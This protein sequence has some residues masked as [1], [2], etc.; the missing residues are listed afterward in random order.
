MLCFSRIVILGV[1]LWKKPV[2]M[3]M[4][5]DFYGQ[6][7][8]EKQQEYFCA[9]LLQRKSFSFR[10]SRDRG[11]HSRQGC[12][13]QTLSGEAILTETEVENRAF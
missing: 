8:T 4:L 7:L 5:F 13:G 11:H 1:S 2:Y 10:N 12:A 3:S 6:L 9:S